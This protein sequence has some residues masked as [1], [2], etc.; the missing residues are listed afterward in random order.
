V[1][2]CPTC[3]GTGDLVTTG[4][5]TGQSLKCP[6][7]ACGKPTHHD[8]LF[9]ED[10]KAVDPTCYEEYQVLRCRGCDA[11]SFRHSHRSPTH[12]LPM[13]DGVFPAREY[14]FPHRH[15]SRAPVDV[16]WLPPNIRSIYREMHL[17]L[18]SCLRTLTAIG[19]RAT[20]EAVCNSKGHR[21]ERCL[22]K[23]KTFAGP[24]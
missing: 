8:I 10:M 1:V 18:R 16:H 9:N 4:I 21:A 24:I 20:I 3:S 22:R 13:E 6:C 15:L 19:A 7:N 5:S 14:L 12:G 2:N 11:I 17:A 23:W